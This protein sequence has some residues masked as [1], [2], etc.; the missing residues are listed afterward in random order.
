MI[1]K[2]FTTLDTKTGMFRPPFF[3]TH[4]AVAMRMATDAAS[5]L[6]TELG[7]HPEDFV[8]TFVGEYDDATGQMIPTMP[9]AICTLAGLVKHPEASLPF[10]E[11]IHVVTEHDA[12]PNG[13]S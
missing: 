3:V 2:A 10:E 4:Q 8:L 9:Q 7:R 11:P 12:R 1:F 13:R 5:D 6:G